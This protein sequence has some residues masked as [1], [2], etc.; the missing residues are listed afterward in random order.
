MRR[1]AAAALTAAALLGAPAAA[2]P[3]AHLYDPEIQ[4]APGAPS[5]EALRTDDAMVALIKDREKLSL[6]AFRGASGI[7]L[8][9]YGHAK[10]A[11]PGL[12]ITERE[13]EWLLRQDLLVFEAAVKGALRRPVR[14]REFSAMVDLAYNAGIG[15]FL[16]SSVLK[17]F[18]DGDRRGAADAFLPWNKYRRFGGRPRRSRELAE[19][20]RLDRA[21]FLGEA[22]RPA[23]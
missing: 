14:Q 19:R 9:G 18:N 2:S 4:H 17:R 13:A 21:H 12:R 16:G 22:R 6:R 15:A 20:R 5:F 10:G 23:R 7:W 3:F 1:L 8:I 11:R